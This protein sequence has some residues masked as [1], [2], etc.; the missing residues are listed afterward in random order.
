MDFIIVYERKQRELENDT[1]LKIELEKRGYTCKIVQYYEG[2]HFNI[3]NI[4]PP[5]VILVPHLYGDANIYRTFSR[6]GRANHIVN[7]QYEQVLS[8]KWEKLGHHDP[9]EQ[10][11]QAIH[12]CW[13][14]K[15]KERLMNA[16]VSSEKLKV[17]G[18]PHLDLLR[19][20]YRNLPSERKKHFSEKYNLTFSKK[21]V[22][23]L[24]SF[25][26]ANISDS[27]LSMNEASAGIKLSDF[28]EIHT[29]SRNE[30]LNWFSYI[31]EKDTE[32]IFIYRPH[33]DELMLDPVVKL[34]KKFLNFK[35]IRDEPVKQWINASDV[36]YSWYSTSVVEAHFL[37]KPY[38]ILRPKVLPDTFDSVLLK[39]AN[40]ITDY[41]KFEE[42]Y[43]KDNK[44][45]KTAIDDH[46]VNQYYLIDTHCS[47]FIKYVDLLETLHKT[48]KQMFSLPIHQRI[49]ATIKTIS[50]KLVYILYKYQNINLNKYRD[51]SSLKRNFFIE[52]FIEMDNQIVSG[53]EK[54]EIESRLKVI[55]KK[56]NTHNG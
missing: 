41:S 2:N 8:K 22:L 4:N 55:L 19:K 53:N 34:E 20:E 26:Y 17:L 39:H 43:F 51:N 54:K 48:K 3:F 27:R 16:G 23:F 30:I 11:M 24:S 42:D 14:E 7:L 15:T 50:A 12:I 25:T 1:L 18:A 29:N 37:D 28:R 36:I 32:N 38:A 56:N 46:H 6:F 31:L 13:G 40:F 52:W 21:W 9:K 47:S 5:K 33:P 49:L 35:I 10:A 44:N 45:R